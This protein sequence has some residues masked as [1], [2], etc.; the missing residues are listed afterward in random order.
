[1]TTKQV[2]VTKYIAC[3][4]EEFNTYSECKAHEREKMHELDYEIRNKRIE[5]ITLKE[6]AEDIRLK[7]SLAKCDAQLALNC[8][9]IIA[10]HEK[11]AEYY[12]CK[13]N[14]NITKLDLYLKRKLLNEFLDQFYLWFGGRKHKAKLA[15]IERRHKSLRWRQEN[16]PD[17]WRTPRKEN[18]EDKHEA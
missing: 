6:K 2:T 13:I 1:M 4:G 7:F 16:T 14:Y 10:F 17:K 5:I 12:N 3:Y 9:N 18:K 11:M 8:G 15:R